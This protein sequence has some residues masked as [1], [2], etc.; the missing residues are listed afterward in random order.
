LWKYKKEFKRYDFVPAGL[1]YVGQDVEPI[2]AK[3]RFPVESHV[4]GPT[5]TAWKSIPE[6][7]INL[8][9]FNAEAQFKLINSMLNEP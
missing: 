3:Y 7:S 8:V 9:W 4:Y 5:K 2:A 6:G 1:I